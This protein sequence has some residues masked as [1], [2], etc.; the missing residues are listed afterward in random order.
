VKQ[1]PYQIIINLFR[2]KLI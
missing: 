1:A 2:K